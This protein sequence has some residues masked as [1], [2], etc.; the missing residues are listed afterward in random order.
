M[1]FTI[2]AANCTITSQT[3]YMNFHEIFAFFLGFYI[4]SYYL[5]ECLGLY[6][7]FLSDPA[8]RQYLPSQSSIHSFRNI[9]FP[10]G[11]AKFYDDLL[12]EL[13]LYYYIYLDFFR[14]IFSSFFNKEN[15]I[16]IILKKLISIS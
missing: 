14:K 12:R 8:F 6:P 10:L 15:I 5:A 16:I 7:K 13:F 2:Y 4:F 11:L 9:S 3:I 1:D